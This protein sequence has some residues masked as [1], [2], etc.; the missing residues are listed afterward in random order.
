MK[1]RAKV[2]REDG[3]IIVELTLSD[4]TVCR[5]EVDG[6]GTDD[7]LIEKALLKARRLGLIPSESPPPPPAKGR[8]LR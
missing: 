8:K 7:E 5:V 4:G 3:R 6:P 2:I 1:I